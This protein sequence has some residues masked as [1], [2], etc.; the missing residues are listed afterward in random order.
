MNDQSV[1]SRAGE[2]GRRQGRYVSPSPAGRESRRGEGKRAEEARTPRGLLRAAARG[3]GG[4]A[5]L[6]SAPSS[7]RGP[8][9]P[10]S[11]RPPRTRFRSGAPF[12][13]WRSET[14]RGSGN[15][16][17]GTA[18]GV[19]ARHGASTAGHAATRAQSLSKPRCAQGTTTCERAAESAR[20]TCPETDVGP[21]PRAS[22]PIRAH[23]GRQ[24]Q[25]H[26]NQSF[27]TSWE[28][29]IYKV[30]SS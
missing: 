26:P 2:G 15:P 22:G 14:Q 4:A 16:R 8:P 28:S 23:L 11:P 24:I 12:G 1:S 20:D 29:R 27:L 17:R 30:V 25:N 6:R 5:S 21:T 3:S 9:A 13:V 19:S 7:S 18:R 10:A